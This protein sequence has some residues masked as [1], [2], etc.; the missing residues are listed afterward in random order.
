VF[1]EVVNR[2]RAAGCVFAEE[3]AE[4]LLAEAGT[5]QQL[6]S[7]VARR[8]GGA[9]LEQILGWA[10]FCGLRIAVEPGVFVPRQRTGFLVQQAA[11]LLE[12]G[13]VVVDL[14]CGSGAVGAALLELVPGLD[15]YACDVDPVAVHCA[16]RNL[17]DRGRVLAGDL[18][19][20]LPRD[21]L[22]RVKVL[23]VNA[24]YVPSDAIRLMPPEARDH[25]PRVALDGGPDGV[26]V[27]RLVA[28][29]APA[30]LRT[31]GALL[32]ETGAHQ[33]P[34]TAAAIALAGLAATVLTSDELDATL[35]VGRRPT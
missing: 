17:G 2:L 33:A 6:E 24:P 26:D 7:M 19:A 34:A 4:L 12:P 29:E 15:L 28:A 31:G 35:V 32:I 27:Q 3:E 18:F 16:G 30:W 21:L 25:E 14:C 20:A 13:D 22:G 23:A 11:R 1:V 9:P 5:P 8:E 10:E